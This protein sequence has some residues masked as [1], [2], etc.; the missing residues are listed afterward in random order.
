MV[1]EENLPNERAFHGAGAYGRKMI[2]YG[3]HN[4]SILQDYCV[5]DTNDNVWMPAPNMILFLIKFSILIEIG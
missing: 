3:G 2:I 5:F 1:S 4:K